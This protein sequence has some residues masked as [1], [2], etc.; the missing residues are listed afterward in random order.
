MIPYFESIGHFYFTPIKSLKYLENNEVVYK[1]KLE[2]YE[3]ELAKK[4]QEI[5]KLLDSKKVL[6]H[7]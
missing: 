2:Y 6:L 4:E 3:N 7:T 5:I 1:A